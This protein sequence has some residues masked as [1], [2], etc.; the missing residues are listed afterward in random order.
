MTKKISALKVLSVLF[1][2]LLVGIGVAFNARAH[3]GN[4]S[5]GI[6]YDG[7]RNALGVSPANL[8]MASNLVNAGLVVILFFLGRRYLNIGTFIYILPYGFCVDFGN[9]LYDGLFEG[10]DFGGRVI[11]V[12]IGCFLLYTGVAIYIVSDIGL[13]PFTGTAMLISDALKT[14]F[15]KGKWIFDIVLIALGFAMGGKFGVVTFLT[16]IFAGPVIQLIAS[17]LRTVIIFGTRKAEKF[18]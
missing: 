4:D 3:L 17:V 1:G 18:V 5:V 16:F 2:I 6:F 14:Q 15:R 13:D 12:V 7:I 10:A 8:G 11:A 9:I